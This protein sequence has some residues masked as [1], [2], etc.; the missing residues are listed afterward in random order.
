M[1][2]GEL[3]SKPDV[4]QKDGVMMIRAESSLRFPQTSNQQAKAPPDSGA[5]TV[6]AC[7]EMVVIIRPSFKKL[8]GQDA[9]RA[10]LFNHLLYWIAQKAK[11]QEAST[12]GSV[13]WYGTAEEICAGLDH[14][15]SVNKVRK[16][17]KALVESG[18]IGQR[19]NPVKGWDQTRHYFFGM[20]Q[21]KGL[22][23]LCEHY[24]VN[25]LELGLPIA[26]LHLLNLGNAIP[27]FGKCHS[28][29]GEMDSPHLADGFPKSGNAIPKDFTKIATKDS[30]KREDHPTEA[31]SVAALTLVSFSNDQTTDEIT[32]VPQIAGEQASM[33]ASVA[34]GA[35]GKASHQRK[36]SSATTGKTSARPKRD[37]GK[38]TPSSGAVLLLEAWDEINGRALPRAKEQVAA[39]EELARI[40]ATQDDL[41]NVRDCLLS[42]K[43]GFWKAR[44]VSLKNISNNFHLA[45]LGPMPPRASRAVAPTQSAASPADKGSPRKLLRR[46][47]SA[48]Q[49]ELPVGTS[50]EM[51]AAL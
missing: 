33:L 50:P 12:S 41:R 6:S 26:M 27:K 19:R 21:G 10:A 48:T 34:R 35:S 49:A 1:R 8:C 23:D 47:P 37:R 42:Q 2:E 43:D 9:C 14:C 44:G 45:A 32:S 16:E 25:L 29:M 39:A 46:V 28:Q 18:L 22:K 24:G 7:H 15:W 36:Q 20:E 40:K 4:V 31:T 30:P 51:R 17:I 11:G 13:Y 5:P 3:V 38:S